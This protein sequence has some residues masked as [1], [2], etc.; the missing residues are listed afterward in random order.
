MKSKEQTTQR[1]WDLLLQIYGAI[2]EAVY[3]FAVTV[4]TLAIVIS[5]YFTYWPYFFP[6]ATF[7]TGSIYLVLL[8]MRIARRFHQD[9][10]YSL[11]DIGSSINHMND[12]LTEKMNE[13]I[14]NV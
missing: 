1:I 12:E 13:V 7:T 2:T 10:Q 8:L 5:I 9:G 4:I 6:W 3:D 14:S 11:N